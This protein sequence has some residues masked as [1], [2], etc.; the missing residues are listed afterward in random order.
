MFQLQGL[1]ELIAP[2]GIPTV[3][4]LRIGHG[5][6]VVTVPLGVRARLDADSGRLEIIEAALVE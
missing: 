4:G 5:Q 3:A 2:L 1:D 6:D